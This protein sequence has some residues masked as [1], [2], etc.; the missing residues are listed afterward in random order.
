MRMVRCLA[1]VGCGV[2]ALGIMG[3]GQGPKDMQIQAQQEEINRL[4]AE[5]QDLMGRLARALSDRDEARGRVL[6]LHQQLADLR[7]LRAA[8]PTEVRQE[9]PWTEMPG[10]AWQ[11]LAVDILFDSGKAKLKSAGKT[12][13]QQVVTDIRQRYPGRQIWIIGHTDSDPI[14]KSGWK[15]NLEL[16]VQRACSVFRELQQAGL[17]AATLVAAGQGEFSPKAANEAKTKHLNRRVEIIAVELP[18]RASAL[19]PADGS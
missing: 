6:D 11:D 5:K 7:A 3:C 1:A 14:S 4:E 2:V 10:I 9:G 17:N 19:Q 16:S 15:D 12:A 8:E 13:L 18:D